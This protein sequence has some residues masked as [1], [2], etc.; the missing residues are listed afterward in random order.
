MGAGDKFNYDQRRRRWHQLIFRHGLF[1]FN[2][3]GDNEWPVLPTSIKIATTF[4]GM[5]CM[6]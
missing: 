4:L 2:P 3:G 1:R 5:I 6:V